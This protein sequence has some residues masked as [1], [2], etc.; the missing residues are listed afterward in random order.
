MNIAVI[1]LIRWLGTFVTVCA[2]AAGL[3]WLGSRDAEWTL[4]LAARE[5][6]IWTGVAALCTSCILLL[7]NKY[8]LTDVLMGGFAAGLIAAAA[9]DLWEQMIYRFVWWASG[10]AALA[11]LSIQFCAGE[12]AKGTTGQLVLYII[13]QQTIFA[14][15]YGRAD[16]H[17]FSVCALGM[18]ALGMEFR[19]YLVH[20]ALT[21]G[22]LTAVQL[23]LGNVARNGRLKRPV[24]LV[25]YIAAAFW[26][27]VDFTVGKWYI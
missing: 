19:D 1:W 20:M 18:A 12:T 21:F 15:F 8:F 13:L 10:A 9:M 27:W 3:F 7:R 6:A 22:A 4:W 23:A 26:L 16:C 5:K 25:P 17:A 11:A 24:P 2:A 14:R